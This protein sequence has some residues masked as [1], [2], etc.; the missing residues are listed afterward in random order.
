MAKL[1]A[2]S[3]IPRPIG[4]LRAGMSDVGGERDHS[5]AADSGMVLARVLNPSIPYHRRESSTSIWNTLQNKVECGAEAG[6]L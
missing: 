1:Q 2:P 5:L 3:G 6:E 4:S